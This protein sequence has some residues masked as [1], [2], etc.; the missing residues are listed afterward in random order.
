MRICWADQFE[1]PT[2]PLPHSLIAFHFEFNFHF[3]FEVDFN[4]WHSH[5]TH[6]NRPTL[7]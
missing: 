6:G 7:H 5:R 3:N 4:F 1:F 2:P